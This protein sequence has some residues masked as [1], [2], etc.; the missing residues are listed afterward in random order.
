MVDS[1]STHCIQFI[2]PIDAIYTELSF[3]LWIWNH[4]QI[5]FFLPSVFHAG[6]SFTYQRL[7]IGF[8]SYVTLSRFMH[9]TLCLYFILPALSIL[10][11]GES[12]TKKF[13][14]LIL[15][16]LLE[17]WATSQTSFYSL[18]SRPSYLH[19]LMRGRVIHLAVHASNSRLCCLDFRLPCRSHPSCPQYFIWGRFTYQEFTH[20]TPRL[21]YLDL[22]VLREPHP[23]SS[24]YLMRGRVTCQE[25]S[26]FLPSVFY[27]GESFTHQGLRI[28]FYGYVTW[29][30]SHPS[31]L[32]YLTQEGSPCIRP[33]C[34]HDSQVASQSSFL[35]APSI[36]RENGLVLCHV[37]GWLAKKGKL[38]FFP[39]S[40]FSIKFHPLVVTASIP[41][42]IVRL[43][44]CS[45]I[46][47]AS[48]LSLPCKAAAVAPVS[49]VF[50]S[51]IG[52]CSN[53]RTRC[54]SILGKNLPTF[55]SQLLWGTYRLPAFIRKGDP[56]ICSM[57]ARIMVYARYI[58]LVGF[59][60]WNLLNGI[61][62]IESAWWSS[63]D[64]SARRNLL[65]GS[66]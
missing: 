16:L 17:P 23:C 32:Q 22:K 61:C 40:L 34:T 7:R 44:S 27:A 12:L 30:W 36:L 6:E 13:T 46:S 45:F 51:Y 14:H 21:C 64:E 48:S 15:R 2:D 50:F 66:Y 10:C 63:L 58:L 29:K 42:N 65:D 24:K 57:R 19:Y 5:R 9:L 25:I 59:A 20:L 47:F 60:R 33:A 8:Y 38:K 62:S 52:F 56:T 53:A 26:S 3:L 43:H 4:L 28:S 18:L 41:L 54:Y 1:P 55:S 11:G 31:Y 35:F 37:S 49:F 39:K